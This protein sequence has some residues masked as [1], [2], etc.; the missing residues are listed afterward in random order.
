MSEHK[1]VAEQA[2]VRL[3]RFVCD[4]L[5]GLSR[6]SA[7][8]G[9]E[10]GL[11]RVNGARAAAGRRLHEGDLV[12][13][14]ALQALGEGPIVRALPEPGLP[15]R[16][17][18]EDAQLLVVDKPA[19]MPSHPL[20]PGERG[21]LASALLARYPE[22]AG[23]GYSAREPGLVHR[24]DTGTSGLLLVARDAASFQ[25]LRSALREGA[26]E[27]RYQALCAGSVQAP[28]VREAFLSARGA[29]VTVRDSAFATAEPIATEL[30]AAELLSGY[31]L[32]T[33]RA[34]RARR[35]QLRAHL[36]ALGHPIVGDA[37]YGGPALPGLT[38]HL[39]HASELA[40]RHPRTGANVRVLA[41]LPAD[42]V[43]AL[44]A[45]QR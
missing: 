2:G 41:E 28:A 17:L 10:Q 22:L 13:L 19:G 34:A 38:R 29:R 6:A 45:V 30:L 7:R 15:L 32:V 4:H 16:V 12:Q 37:R 20:A 8:R 31:S 42:F 40:L 44:A 21:T 14:D 43:A 35:H 3:D 27:K 1:V 23:V 5:T 36:A 25:A 24:L 39:L 9:I 11:V 18:H 26:I 33:V